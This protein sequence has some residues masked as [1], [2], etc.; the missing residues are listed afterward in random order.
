MNFRPNILLTD[1]SDI[2]GGGEYFV[3]ELADALRQRMFEITVVCRSDNLLR[4][5]CETAHIPF[6]PLDFPANG[7]L[8]GVVSRL[9][10]IV[11]DRAI[12]IVHTNNNYDRTAGAFAAL[13][14]GKKHVTNIH[15]FH[16]ISHNLT[17]WFRNRFATDQFLVDGFCVRDL[18]VNE[19]GIPSSKISVL[20]L[21][22][23]PAKMKRNQ[24]DR[25][26]IR[27]EFG[28]HD[29]EIVIGNVG[30]LVP[31]KGQE[32]LVR[33]FAEAAG[34]FP[35]ARLL[36]VGDGELMAHLR[37]LAENLGIARH[38]VFAGFRDDLPSL[39][40][41]FDIYA[42]SSI[43][44]GGETFPFAVLQALAQELPAVV[45]KV[46]DVAEMVED[47][48]NG[49]VV[50]DGKA[51]LLGKALKHVLADADLRRKMSEESYRRFLQQFTIEKMVDRIEAVYSHVMKSA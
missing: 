40:S 15:S 19:D 26:R 51:D 14:A 48:K 36:I 5:K 45:T 12:D 16:S 43:E 25:D 30:R 32:F 10:N 46:G 7:G 6:V 11:I 33:A 1:S 21:G 42:H 29:D 35:R 28:F 49:V 27:S 4:E 37:S 31:M 18:L 41:S 17:H 34:Q 23:D 3:L 39:Y 20:H 2:Y 13:L 22:V 44:G 47:G 8:P 38:V 9:K 50:P 24:R